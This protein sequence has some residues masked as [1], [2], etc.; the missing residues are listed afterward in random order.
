MNKLQIKHISGVWRYY[1]VTICSGILIFTWSYRNFLQSG[2]EDALVG[3]FIL[4]GVIASLAVFSLR[5]STFRKISEIDGKAYKRLLSSK[6]KQ[7]PLEISK[8]KGNEYSQAVEDLLK[9]YNIFR[10]ANVVFILAFL[11]IDF[12]LLM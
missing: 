8:G 2:N 11:I 5:R 12:L 3:Y 1:F 9:A 7:R 10:L 6:G 4:Y